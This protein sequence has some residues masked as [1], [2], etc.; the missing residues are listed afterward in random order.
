M[1][2]TLHASPD[3]LRGDTSLQAATNRR[4]HHR[5]HHLRLQAFDLFASDEDGCISIDEM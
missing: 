1:H 4:L 2:V 3:T 5:V